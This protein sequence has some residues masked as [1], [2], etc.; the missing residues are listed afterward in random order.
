MTT[1]RNYQK[2]ILA[3]LGSVFDEIEV[4][5][6]MKLPQETYTPRVDVAI[7]PFAY[8]DSLS[9]KYNW[10]LSVHQSLLDEI[11]E[12]SINKDWLNFNVNRN[13]RCFIAIE[14]E[15]STEKDTKHLLGSI[16]NASIL[17]KVGILIV[18]SNRKGLQ[19]MKNY[20]KFAKD[21]YK[22]T[23]YLFQNVAL[24]IK[25]DFDKIFRIN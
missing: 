14:I 18:F 7:G 8:N 6:A 21:H 9:E 2:K 16:T 22:T 17:G 10:L 15:N 3:K 5:E 13:P 24:I 1:V 11:R 20:L 25:E 4:E 12:N 19:N 23:D